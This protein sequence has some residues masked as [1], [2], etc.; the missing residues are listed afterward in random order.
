MSREAHIPLALWISAAILVHMAGGGGAIEAA[1]LVEERAQFRAMV[2]AVRDSLR[3]DTTFEILVDGTPATP[4]TVSLPPPENAP[5]NEDDKTEPE[6]DP[7]KK[8][9]IEQEKPKPKTLKPP[10]PKII[11]PPP[12]P[13][14]TAK[15]PPPPPPQATKPP[16]PP[17][18]PLV[19]KEIAKVEPVKPAPPPPPP[20]PADKRLAVKQNVKKDQDDNPTAKRIADDA[21]HTEEETMARVRS[22]D[23][24]APD[25]TA[26][27]GGREKGD[28]GNSDHNKV[29]QS[30]DKAGNPDHAP[31]EAAKSSTSVEHHNPATA[32][33]PSLGT[34]RAAGPSMPGSRGGGGNAPMAPPPSEAS[35]GSP[36]GSGPA[37]PE[38]TASGQGTWRIDPANPGGDGKS[39]VAGRKRAATPYQPP[40]SVGQTGLGAPGLPGGPTLNL[41]MSGLEA[42]VGHDQLKRERAAD[43]AARKT[44][45]RGSSDPNKFQRMRA[46]IENYDPSVKP[47]NQTSLNA[48]R[49]PFASYLNAIHNRIHPIFAEEFLAALE[50]LPAQHAMN[51]NLVTHIEIVLSKDEGR[52]V[53]LGVTRG[54]GSTA[55]DAVALNSVSRASPFGK[56]PDVIVSPDGNVYIHWEFHRDPFDACTTRN[57]RPY[58]LKEAPAVTPAPGP[59]KRPTLGPTSDDRGV[60]PAPLLPLRKP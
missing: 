15:P 1:R 27:S 42:A 29:A 28:P 9:A 38:V 7:E 54:S 33:R 51:Q 3:P 11:K 50:N 34:S 60:G 52:I 30:E 48:A 37:S 21:N 12:P 8:D 55:F 26:G 14:E 44:A 41:T 59:P 13:K 16:P 5:E 49:V 32:S 57:A 43:G 31:G 6:D 53:R 18:P 2:H 45:H 35:P 20:P 40:V 46:A 47:G 36:G 39:R 17:P 4:S 23:H 58:L 22:H 24:D 56:A 25:P 19:P 10:P